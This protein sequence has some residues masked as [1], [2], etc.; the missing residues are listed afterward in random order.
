MKH[1]RVCYFTLTM[2]LSLA[3]DAAAADWPNWRGPSR[4]GKVAA[5]EFDPAFAQGGAD[6]LWSADLGVG[7][8]GITVADGRAYTAGWNNGQ[9][10]FY[11]FNAV[12]GQKLWDHSFPTKKYDN[13]N[14]G[15][16]SGTAAVDDGRVYHMARDGRFVCY[17]A[18]DQGGVVWEK[19]LTQQYGVKVP[20]WGFSGSPVIIGDTLYLDIGRI[21]ALNKTTGREIWKTKDYGPA[22]STPAP[23]TY[24][25]KHYLAVFPESGLYILER[26][27]GKQVAHYPWKTSYGVHA[28]TPVI[29]G[30]NQIF[31]SSDYNTGCA[32]L[33]FDGRSLDVDWDNK[34]LKN[35]MCTSV[36]HDGALY[37]FDSSKL[38]CIDIETGD[39]LWNQRGLGR[40][41]VI[42]AGD[43]LIVLS[44]E[45]Q[46]L[47]AKATKDGF[48]PIGQVQLVKGDRTVWTAPTLAN[49]RLYIRGSKGKLVCVDVS[50]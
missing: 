25:G 15:G 46:V 17:N 22:Y 39:E 43:Y 4:D 18:N 42:M 20:R 44:D 31:I 8:T 35:Q 32:L 5:A 47:T 7:F 6:I 41:T 34:N 26:D 33:T 13:L 40:G 10:T 19:N 12:T 48:K 23:F 29:I 28:A 36:Y 14:V 11:C 27:S 21:I 30:D 3:F 2:V 45:G 38:T 16:P 9:T 50:K 37:G 49:G 24:R 1:N